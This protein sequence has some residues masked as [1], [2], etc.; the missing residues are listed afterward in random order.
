M[1]PLPLRRPP[2]ADPLLQ[3]NPFIIFSFCHFHVSLP[4]LYYG[5]HYF[6]F[7]ASLSPVLFS[8][9]PTRRY[10]TRFVTAEEKKMIG[11]RA[12]RGKDEHRSE[13]SCVRTGCEKIEAA[14]AEASSSDGLSRVENSERGQNDKKRRNE[15]R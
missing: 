1:F 2:P 5:Y 8:S 4:L 7:S 13:E 6:M 10:P 14:L 15:Q 9:A 11:R 3:M 12:R